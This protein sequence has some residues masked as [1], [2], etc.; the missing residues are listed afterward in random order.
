[1][2][3]RLAI[4]KKITFFLPFFMLLLFKNKKIFYSRQLI[5]AYVSFLQLIDIKSVTVRVKICRKVFLLVCF[6]KY[7]AILVQNMGKKKM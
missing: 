4:K 1:M 7:R 6:P 2:D 3:K 5:T